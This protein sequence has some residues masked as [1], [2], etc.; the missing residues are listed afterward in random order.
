MTQNQ[1][2][3]DL[4]NVPPIDQLGETFGMANSLDFDDFDDFLPANLP[5]IEPHASQAQQARHLDL[6]SFEAGAQNV[7]SV[8]AQ[9]MQASAPSYPGISV[10]TATS[11]GQTVL[12]AAGYDL[13][14]NSAKYQTRGRRRG[15]VFRTILGVLIT[16][17]LAYG[18]AQVV[19]GMFKENLNQ[20]IQGGN[21]TEVVNTKEALTPM[22]STD[23]FYMLL[24]GADNSSE[25]EGEDQRSDTNIV[26]RVD[27]QTGTVNI[28]SIPRDTAINLEG[29]G[30][31]K[32]NAAYA[33]YGTEGAIKAS[34]GLLGIKIS[35][36][37]QVD[38]G[39]LVELVNAIGG[40]DVDV[41]MRIED[42]NAGEG[43]IEAGPQHL[44]GQQALIFA[45]SRSYTNGDFQR[46]ANQRI[47]IE[48]ILTKVAGMS[49]LELVPV[50]DVVA[51]YLKSDMTVDQMQDYAL[52]MQQFEHVNI[53]S[54]MVPSDTTDAGGVS[55][56]VCDTELLRQVMDV[57]NQGGDPSYLINDNSAHSSSE[58]IEMGAEST[59]IYVP[60]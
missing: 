40:V 12:P 9:P 39:G 37:A 54:V 46:T 21:T 28:I 5:E 7:G 55:Y 43:V 50:M 27:P 11:E 58:A 29:Y 56:V 3:R 57:V 42:A 23:P 48:A 45:R 10:I 32:F 35:H 24:I 53:Y 13:S 47:L 33:Y 14:R 2:R 6:P 60:D 19:K 34:E 1:N 30:T 51:N 18:V 31:Q 15:R 4:G 26:A 20:R 41:P 16:L 38:F 49:K 52:L 25:E 44:D 36:Y 22:V 17:L 59:P 8:Q